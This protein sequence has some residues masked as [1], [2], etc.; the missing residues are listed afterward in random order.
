MARCGAKTRSGTPCQSQAMENGRCRMHGGTST[1][2]PI[3]NKNAAKHG[4]YSTALLPGE[5]ECAGDLRNSIGAVED[6]LFITRL[7]LRRALKAEADAIQSN[8]F[9]V[10]DSEVQRDGDGKAYAA[11][12]TH[13]KRVD[14]T[15]IIDRLTARIESLEKTRAELQKSN[16]PGD[17]PVTRIE[18]EVVAPKEVKS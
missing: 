1:G 15:A 4:I 11:A 5:D 18:I 13:L 7:R 17:E 10:I 16:P 9:L 8:N 3:G 12:E 2:A 6:E 14:Y